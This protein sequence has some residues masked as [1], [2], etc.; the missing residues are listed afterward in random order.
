MH[1]EA[2]KRIGQ[3]KLLRP[4]G[5]GGNGTVWQVVGTEENEAAIKIFHD[6]R[7]E[8]YQRFRDEVATLRRLRDRS[9][10]MPILDANLPERPR[11]NTPAWLVMPVAEP[12]ALHL[13]NSA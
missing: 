8:R 6:T 12:L 9:G 5:K 11:A 1:F 7:P 4:L 2:G 10:V 3:W 13:R